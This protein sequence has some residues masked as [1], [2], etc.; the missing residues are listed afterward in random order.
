MLAEGFVK[1]KH[2]RLL[3]SAAEPEEMLDHLMS[4]RP[5]EGLDKWFDPAER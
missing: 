4:Y 5:A 2:R 3:L 1:P